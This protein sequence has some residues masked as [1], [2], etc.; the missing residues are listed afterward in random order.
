MKRIALIAFLIF[1]ALG[2]AA[3]GGGGGGG[4]APASGGP[5]LA[6]NQGNWNQ[7]NWQ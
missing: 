6:W 5:P 7:S 3:C 4:D 1:F 2:L